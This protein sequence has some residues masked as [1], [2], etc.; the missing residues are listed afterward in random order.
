MP[1]W[2]LRMPRYVRFGSGV[3]ADLGSHLALLEGDQILLTTDPT[4]SASGLVEPVVD[5]VAR[6]GLDYQIFDRFDEQPDIE[7]IQRGVNHVRSGSFAAILAVGGGSVVDPSK[8]MALLARNEGAVGDVVSWFG[9]GFGADES[10]AVA[11]P[12]PLFTIP[13]M[14]SGADFVPAA[15]V[16]DRAAHTKFANWSLSM[17]PA[18]S[19][20]DPAFTASAPHDALVDAAL[21]SF[22]HALEGLTVQRTSPVAQQLALDAAKR[23]FKSLP[24][25]YESDDDEAR[26][27]LCLGCM[28][29]GLVVANT[30]A[31]AIHG[32]SYPISANFPI[33]HGRSLAVLAP[34]LT[35]FNAEAASEEYE[36]LGIALGI[37][38]AGDPGAALADAIAELNQRVGVPES[39]ADI[40]ATESD[41][42]QLVTAAE[43][44]SW[45]FEN[46]PRPLHTTDIKA[47]YR[48]SLIGG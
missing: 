29:A 16:T 39:L 45:F 26:T 9:T 17:M 44:N 42:P 5:I 21:D 11:A 41:I 14:V 30:R 18:G 19:F 46:N 25:I 27:D 10:R 3:V 40:G 47:L 37:R 20:V 4:V 24:V 22:T 8:I 38:G 15:V 28:E 7:T 13:T 12:L 1:V 32:L 23:I 35:R 2:D 34:A 33:T 48:A 36:R 31:A 6:S 43:R